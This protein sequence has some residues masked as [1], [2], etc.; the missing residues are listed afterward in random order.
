[1]EN[2][3]LLTT[4]STLLFIRNKYHSLAFVIQIRRI[5][6]LPLTYFTTPTYI[7]RSGQ[8]ISYRKKENVSDEWIHNRGQK[9]KSPSQQQR[10]KDFNWH[11][12]SGLAFTG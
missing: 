2:N 5:I 9:M 4:K 7:I 12:T 3:V 8:H 1:V 11:L 6:I 10:V